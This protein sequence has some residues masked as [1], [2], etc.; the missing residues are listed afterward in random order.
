MKAAAEGAPPQA[1]TTAAAAAS[2]ASATAPYPWGLYLHVIVVSLIGGFA[3]MAWFVV[4]EGLNKLIWDNELRH[5]PRLD[6]PGHL[7]AVL[8]ARRPA[9]EV[10]QG[11]EQPRRLHPRQP[12]GRREPPEVEGPAGDRGH[13]AGLAVLWRRARPRGRHRQHRQQDRRHVLRPLQDPADRRP[14]LVFASVASG[15]NG[16]L[17]N[18]VFA[19]VLGT[20]VA[21]TKQQGLSH[22]ARRPHRRR[23]RLRRVPAA[24]R[25]RVRQLPA[26]AAGQ[27]SACGRGP[28]GAAG[29]AR[30]GSGRAH[31]RVHE[32]RRPAS[33]AASRTASCCGRS[34]PASSS[35]SSACSRPSSCSPARRRCRRSSTAPPATASPCCW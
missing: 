2:Q 35:A 22:P 14:K 13:V 24:A 11:P 20:E 17:E 19:A 21:E 33:S 34:W 12:H 5:R 10:R 26:P 28:H 30:P 7:P 23:R 1:P 15:Y 32:G 18:P 8:P 6:V 4:Y 27:A 16:L 29:A 31:R 9:R 3:V 25:G